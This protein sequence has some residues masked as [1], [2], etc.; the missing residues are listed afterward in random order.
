MIPA[1]Q[2]R[3]L[4][5]TNYVEEHQARLIELVRDLVRLPSE[6]TPPSGAELACQEYIARV[7]RASEWQ[8]ELYEL[9]DVKGLRAHP[10]FR[11]GR[12]YANRPNLG[13]RRK[14]A[15]GGRSLVL[16]GHVDTVPRGTQPWTRD[17]FGGERDANR[18]YG[19]GSNDMKAGVA[20]NLFI[21][22]ALAEL[23]LRLAGDLVFETVIDEEFG[24]VNGTLAGRLR[25]FNGDAAVISEP[26]FLRVCPAQRGGRTAHITFCSPGGVLTEGRF[27]SGVVE[28][29]THFLSKVPEFAAARRRKA[30]VHELYQR[31]AD[32]VPVSITKIF[33]SPWGTR[34]PITVPEQCKVEFYWQLM[35]GEAQDEVER[36][37]FE[38]L[39]HVVA[40]AP[41]IF[42]QRPKV[43]FPIRWMPGSAILKSE[44][45]VRELAACA[46]A[47]LG[48]EPPIVGIEGPCDMFVFHQAFSIPAVLWGP[49]GGNT[50]AADEYVEID[51]LVDAAKTLMLFVCRW[52]GLAPC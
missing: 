17:A 11:P 8:P 16:S 39:D 27:P 3:E 40:S 37:F 14:G 36:E 46:Q 29:L 51:S 44:P 18:I 30:Q 21:A 1:G 20:M 47:V 12:E 48:A 4:A 43:V 45:L 31:H 34:E 49:R 22:E 38:W 50:H 32:P 28:Q 26:S 42:S 7:L 13:A 33:T 9:A 15:E 35:P 10:L 2:S 6:N 19:R 41:E 5:I 52:C 23:G 24:G 25:G